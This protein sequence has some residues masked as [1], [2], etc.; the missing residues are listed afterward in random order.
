MLVK[1]G[2]RKCKRDWPTNSCVN[3]GLREPTMTV[4]TI[5][6]ETPAA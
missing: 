2:L 5:W 6:Q 1:Q 3:V 4:L